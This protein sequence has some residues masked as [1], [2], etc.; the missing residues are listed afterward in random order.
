MSLPESVQSLN[1]NTEETMIADMP[2]SGGRERPPPDT[3]G[4]SLTNH[5]E[6][7]PDVKPKQS[8]LAN[9][10]LLWSSLNKSKMT[11]VTCMYM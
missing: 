9:F 3:T 11:V 10:D 6:G 2:V 8:E 1:D 4:T 5:H 7:N